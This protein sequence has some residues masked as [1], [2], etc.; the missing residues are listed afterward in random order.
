M[1]VK[2]STDQS[3]A[4][5]E[6]KGSIDR[7][8]LLT[9]AAG[10]ACTGA[11]GIPMLGVAKTAASSGAKKRIDAYTHFSSL[12]FIDL[13]ERQEG[14]P[15]I[16]AG[17]YKHKPSLIDLKAR[18]DLLDRNEIDIHV[19]VPIPWLESFPRVAAD[20]TLAAEAARFMNDELA[21]VVAAQP[22]RFRGVA[23][24]PTVDAETMVAEL[25]RAVKQLGFV[26][27]YVAVG[28]T[29]KRMDHP[30]FDALYKAIID[31]DVTLWLHPSQP[32]LPEYADENAS[33]YYEWIN[34]GWPHD[35]TSAMHRIVFSG[36]FDRYPGIRI[37]T[38]HHGGFL[39]YYAAR[40]SG[41]WDGLEESG[42]AVSTKIS[43]PYIDHF[44][45]FYCDT[46]CNEFAP[47]ILELAL[48]FFGPERVVFASDAPFG[49]ADGQHFTT[50]VLRSIQAM[51]I[52]PE[53]HGAILSGNAGRILKVG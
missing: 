53:E 24:L 22:N 30:D 48:E 46:A 15:I 21:E 18:L 9:V 26:G 42:A 8:T 51:R 33:K 37:V 5:V 35:T 43:K 13:L 25:D 31:L 41:I 3:Q 50:E 36:V 7:R 20:R 49:T 17:Q 10:A 6:D 44:K 38:H 34:I 27:A 23:L 45:K 11:V 39:P 2:D 32:P 40:M 12:K 1:P 28:P 29:A 16:M 4:V 14:K 47:K 52:S 19:L